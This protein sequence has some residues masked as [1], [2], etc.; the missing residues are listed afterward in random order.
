MRRSR[1]QNRCSGST[2]LPHSWHTIPLDARRPRH[3][4]GVVCATRRRRA[5]RMV[6]WPAASHLRRPAS[7][8]SATCARRWSPGSPRAAPVGASSCGWR[9]SI[10]STSSPAHEQRQLADLAALGIDWDGPVVRQSERFD[11][12]RAAIERLRAAGRVYPC[13]CTRREIRAEIDVGRAGAPRAPA[14]RRLSRHVPRAD[15]TTNAPHARP[16]GRRPA[17]RL[18]AGGEVIELVDAHRRPLRGRRRRRRARPRRRRARL[19]PRGRRRRRRQG[20]TQVVRG[21]DLLS[22]TP[23]QVLL[24]RLLGPRPPEYMH[25]PLVLGDD[26]QRLAKRH[27]AVTLGDL[28]GDGWSAGDVLDV[29]ARS[30]GC[31]PAVSGSRSISWSSASTRL[32]SRDRRCI[33][34]TCNDRRRERRR[35]RA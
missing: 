8:I 16:A 5:T 18:R 34:P 13:Y 31:R 27:G 7:C 23:R 35:V 11:L 21:D 2:A 17:L 15:A 25:V 12:Y 19:Q 4:C 14:R 10:G 9:T 24:Q 20:V 29:L 3:P 33:S 26:G 6:A 22:S 28:A 30:L 32:R 1:L